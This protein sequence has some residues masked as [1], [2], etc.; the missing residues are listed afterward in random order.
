MRERAS[1]AYPCA[2]TGL[3]LPCGPSGIH[4]ITPVASSAFAVRS[5]SPCSSRVSCTRAIDEHRSASASRSGPLGVPAAP[6]ARSS[7]PNGSSCGAPI[8]DRLRAPDDA[9]ADVVR[10]MQ[11]AALRGD[12][13][14][15]LRGS[16][17]CFRFR[18]RRR[19]AGAR[20]RHEQQ[21]DD[22]RHRR[23]RAKGDELRAPR[24]FERDRVGHALVA[25]GGIDAVDGP[26]ERRRRFDEDHVRR[27][28][29]SARPWRSRGPSRR[30]A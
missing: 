11:A 29:Q 26:I 19:L 28:E 21:H 16:C 20:D 7:G 18:G 5:R 13:G 12:D 9:V 30:S 15:A 10:Q 6:S 17:L 23:A 27:R 2:R 4:T 14:R 3:R 22:Q 25:A 24:F 1:D 8:R